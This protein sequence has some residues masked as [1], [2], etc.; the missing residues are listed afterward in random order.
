MKLVTPDDAGTLKVLRKPEARDIVL[1]EP[2][3]AVVKA[4]S[5]IRKQVTARNGRRRSQLAS[6]LQ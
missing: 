2:V 5:R 3:V 1:T 6:E 4:K